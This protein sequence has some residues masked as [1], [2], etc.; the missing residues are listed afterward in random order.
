M[1]GHRQFEVGYTMFRWVPLTV[2]HRFDFGMWHKFQG[3]QPKTDPKK[4]F[5]HNIL[6][7]S[8]QKN[9]TQWG[10]SYWSCLQG[11]VEMENR[12]T[13][14]LLIWLLWNDRGIAPPSSNTGKWRLIDV[15]R[16]PLIRCNNPGGDDCIL[17]TF[18]TFQGMSQQVQWIFAS[19][20]ITGKHPM[21]WIRCLTTSPTPMSCNQIIHGLFGTLT[22][23][24]P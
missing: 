2:S 9:M 18:E 4:V 24:I 14:V 10:S 6:Y 11:W 8:S 23:P 17:V 5:I 20:L 7:F 19:C 13:W 12:E 15:N 22:V 1:K 16:D 21:H 3:S